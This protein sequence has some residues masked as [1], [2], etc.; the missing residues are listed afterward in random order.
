MPEILDAK[1]NRIDRGFFN[2]QELPLTTKVWLK[3]WLEDIKEQESLFES[4]M[5][6]RILDQHG[7]RME[8]IGDNTT[9]TIEYGPVR[10]I[11]NA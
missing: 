5:P 7:R 1:G 9:V 3:K 10:S 8:R 11:I 4:I 6:S 2:N